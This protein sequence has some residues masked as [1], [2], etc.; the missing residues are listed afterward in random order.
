MMRRIIIE[1]P[2]AGDVETH[3][4]NA[5]RCIRDALIRGESPLASHLLYTQP[6]ILNDEVPSERAWGIAAGHAWIGVTEAVVF[7]VDYGIS[8]GMG[9]ALD[10]A[11]QNH[12]VIER[13]EI[14]KNP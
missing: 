2:F 14:G 7:Y 13:R 10:L 4:T 12:I 5:R 6:S 11:M 8:K 3:I 1:S 9:I